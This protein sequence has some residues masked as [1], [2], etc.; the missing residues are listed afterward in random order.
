MV[1]TSHFKCSKF[2]VLQCTWKYRHWCFYNFHTHRG[3]KHVYKHRLF[4]N[5]KMMAIAQ[6][7]YQHQCAIKGIITSR[8]VMFIRALLRCNNCTRTGAFDLSI[9]VPVLSITT[10][11]SASKQQVHRERKK[12]IPL[13]PLPAQKF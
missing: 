13:K 12:K 5:K 9:S 6:K 1:L 8:G 4:L 7:L 3:T 2:H 11:T 10:C